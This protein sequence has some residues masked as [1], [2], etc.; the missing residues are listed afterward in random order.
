[1]EAPLLPRH[2]NS[3]SRGELK[4]GYGEAGVEAFEF[5]LADGLRFLKLFVSTVYVDMTALEQSSPFFTVCGA[6][7]KPPS[8]DPSFIVS[9]GPANPPPVDSSFIVHGGRL[10][11]A[12]SADPSF[13]VHG[14]KLVKPTSKDIWDSWTYVVKTRN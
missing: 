2:K 1:M 10:A 8:V 5:W 6:K 13:I 12:P 3:N 7:E 4:V 9:G 14:G 11:N